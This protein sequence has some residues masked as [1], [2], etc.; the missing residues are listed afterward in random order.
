MFRCQLLVTLLL[1]LFAASSGAAELAVAE[2]LIF[3]ID[4]VS[5]WTVHLADPPEALVKEA[6][7]HLAHDPAAAKATPGQIEAVARK[8]LAA[9][10]AILYHASSGAHLDIDFSP[11]DEGAPAPGSKTLKTSAEYAAQ[12]LANEDDVTNAEWHIKAA[13]IAGAGETWLLAA[14]FL[15]H[16]QPMVFRGYVGT[17]EGY[18]F[19]LYFTAPEDDPQV[20]REME[21]MLANASI[22]TVRK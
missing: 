11:L 14:K 20:L 9:N 3:T 8:R 6:A 21:L 4:P 7:I 15:K 5:G 10:E 2:N 16:D 19:F 12:S 18:W 1:C 22:L 13:E 17:V